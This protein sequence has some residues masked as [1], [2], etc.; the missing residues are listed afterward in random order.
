MSERMNLAPDAVGGSGPAQQKTE[1]AR[2]GQLLV[3]LK[4]AMA[5]EEEDRKNNAR[6]VQLYKEYLAGS[7]E[8]YAPH[9]R[10]EAEARIKV[11]SGGEEELR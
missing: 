8:H 1:P 2:K 3:D 10:Q 11:L 9:V 6:A 7:P 5:L 4:F